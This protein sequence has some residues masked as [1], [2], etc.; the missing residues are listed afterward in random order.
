MNINL[1]DFYSLNKNLFIKL[2][3]TKWMNQL[4]YLWIIEIFITD[5]DPANWIFFIHNYIW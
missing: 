1:Y 5:I 2:W 4:K 3:S